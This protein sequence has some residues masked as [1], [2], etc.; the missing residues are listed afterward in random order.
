MVQDPI[1]WR[2]ILGHRKL[3]MYFSATID[4][5]HT[6]VPRC[7]VFGSCRHRQSENKNKSLEDTH[8]FENKETSLKL[9]SQCTHTH[10]HIFGDLERN[11]PFRES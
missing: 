1:T 9:A 6:V 11:H 7:F 3:T 8:P 5:S 4:E 10:T 2:S